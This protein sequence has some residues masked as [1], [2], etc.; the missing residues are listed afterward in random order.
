MKSEIK[1]QEDLDLAI[2]SLEKKT[3]LQKN[4][5]ANSFYQLQE[6]LKPVNLIKKHKEIIFV[7][8]LSLGAGYLIRKLLVK[9]STGLMAKT[10]IT[11]LQWG[12]AGLLS[13]NAHKIRPVVG[14]VAR[15]VLSSNK[16][17]MHIIKVDAR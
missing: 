6:N 10:V 9:K 3:D 5:I 12:V 16:P 14:P 11:L 4:L 8:V 13:K 7:G 2:A 1:N 17:K 15:R